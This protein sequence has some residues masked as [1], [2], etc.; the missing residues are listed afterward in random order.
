MVVRVLSA[1]YFYDFGKRTIILLKESYP[2]GMNM[3]TTVGVYDILA[4][5]N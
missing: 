5:N 4:L 2:L 1:P 3:Q